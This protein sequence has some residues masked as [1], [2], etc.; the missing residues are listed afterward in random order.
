MQSINAWWAASPF[1]GNT[2]CHQHRQI[3]TTLSPI[4]PTSRQKQIFYKPRLHFF[5]PQ[6]RFMSKRRGVHKETELSPLTVGRQ[7]RPSSLA[8]VTA[9][10]F[11]LQQPTILRKLNQ[12]ANLVCCCEQCTLEA[13]DTP[14]Y[15]CWPYILSGDQFI[16]L[17]P[18]FWELYLP[19]S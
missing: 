11:Y 15:R 12:K 5:R 1:V 17:W 14:H 7:A 8:S 2:Y 18:V 3:H 10:S 16:F 6:G 13:A 19:E 4:T 9:L